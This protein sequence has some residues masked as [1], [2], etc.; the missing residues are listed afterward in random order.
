ML[1]VVISEV[2]GSIL[3]RVCELF[4]ILPQEFAFFVLSPHLLICHLSLSS[5]GTHQAPVFIL[6]YL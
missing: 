6:E 2:L 3:H 4:H 5:S 1:L